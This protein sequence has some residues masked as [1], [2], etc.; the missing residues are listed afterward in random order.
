M[1][2]D[3]NADP[4]LRFN[5]SEPNVARIYDYMLGGKNNFQVDRDVADALLKEIPDI[6][7]ACTQNRFFLQ[8]VVRYLVGQCDIRQIID[9]GTGLP[10]QGNVHE[11]AHS[12][13]P[14]VNVVYVDND[15]VVVVHSKSLLVPHGNYNS[16]GNHV[17]ALLADARKPQDVIS[18]V[19]ETGLIDFDSPVALLMLAILHFIPDNEHP[20][21][22][23]RQLTRSLVPGSFIAISHM[24][25]DAVD[26]AVAAA[27]VKSYKAAT[28]VPRSAAEIMMLFDDFTMQPPGL[29][30]IDTWPT[31][32]PD[33]A[34]QARPLMYGGVARKTE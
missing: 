8:R 23:V 19:K 34:E 3:F 2:P 11:A 5:A 26:P 17:D 27:A 24:T 25:D 12:V 29:V 22:T 13:R 1:C 14:D 31:L 18:A 6:E 32:V 4:T 21:Y 7:R 20:D 28:A 10:T 15:P 16:H 9:I 33:G 30:N